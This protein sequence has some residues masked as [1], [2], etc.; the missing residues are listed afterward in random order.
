MIFAIA[1]IA[2]CAF[3]WIAAFAYV[4]SRAPYIEDEEYTAAMR[5]ELDDL[6]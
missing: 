3:A 1:I 6:P 5:E 2:F 4:L